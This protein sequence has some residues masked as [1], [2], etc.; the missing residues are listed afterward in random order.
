LIRLVRIEGVKA[1]AFP[2]A[3]SR[4]GGRGNDYR[5]ACRLFGANSYITQPPELV[6]DAASRH[7]S[8]GT[9]MQIVATAG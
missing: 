1:E 4:S 8:C 5:A 2:P 6:S 9:L 3:A 7:T